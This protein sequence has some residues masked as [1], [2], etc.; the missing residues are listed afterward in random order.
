M[1][2][3]GGRSGGGGGGGWGRGRVGGG[4]GPSDAGR[5]PQAA[6]G[7]AGGYNAPPQSVAAA[8]SQPSRTEP[9]ASLSHEMEQKLT[10][11]AS[12]SQA[13]Q[14]QGPPAA[15]ANPPPVQPELPPA[16]SK[17]VR[18]P[19]RPGFGSHGRKVVVK[20]NHFLTEIGNRDLRHY[21]VSWN[22]L[23]A[24]FCCFFIVYVY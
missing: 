8:P 1:S 22:L 2:G 17:A 13:P 5:G 18:Y 4:R 14:T 11:K 3:R 15:A 19:P 6:R 24:E 10:L 9:A 23:I 12:S 21:D 20:A 7:G 16:S